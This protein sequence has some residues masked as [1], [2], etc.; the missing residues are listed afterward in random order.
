MIDNILVGCIDFHI[1]KPK[2]PEYLCLVT[3]QA[4][5]ESKTWS[6]VAVTACRY[7]FKVYTTRAIVDE[8]NNKKVDVKIFYPPDCYANQR[9]DFLNDAEIHLELSPGEPS[10]S[11]CFPNMSYKRMYDCVIKAPNFRL[12]E[13]ITEEDIPLLNRL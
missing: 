13:N 11:V 9:M 1:A 4:I 7:E 10:E 6:K 2:S 12:H 8:F 3:S 5:T